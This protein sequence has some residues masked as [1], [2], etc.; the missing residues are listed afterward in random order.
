MRST[1]GERPAHTDEAAQQFLPAGLSALREAF[2]MHAAV[3]VEEEGQVGFVETWFLTGERAYVT[4]ESRTLRLDDQHHEWESQLRDLWRDVID[5]AQPTQFYWVTP[6]PAEL[7]T[8]ARLGHL[9]VAQVQTQA[10]V[11][12]HFTIQFAGLGHQTIKFAAA[13]LAVPVR[14]QAA[15]DLL[16]LARL[17]LNR[18]CRLKW[19]ELV[20]SVEDAVQ[21]PAGSGLEFLLDQCPRSSWRG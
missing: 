4:E 18:R 3:E 11:P 15:R 20:W 14:F 8:Q 1:G 2:G 13:L 7:P 9:I 17:C 6:R 10:V 21:V 12:V 5:R 19:R 16:Q